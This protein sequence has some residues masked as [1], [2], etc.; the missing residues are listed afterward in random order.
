MSTQAIARRGVENVGEATNAAA[1]V[2]VAR[3]SAVRGYL[4]GSAAGGGR[5]RARAATSAESQGD[6]P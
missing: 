4:R 5:L 3:R 6:A 1:K 2:V